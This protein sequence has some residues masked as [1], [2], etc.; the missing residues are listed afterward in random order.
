MTID[1]ELLLELVRPDA[2]GRVRK[3]ALIV[4]I[5]GTKEIQYKLEESTYY[6][7]SYGTGEDQKIEFVGITP[8]I[9][10]KIKPK[11]GVKEAFKKMVTEMVM[12]PEV[13]VALELENDIQWDFQDS[14]RQI[15][16]YKKK[17]EDTRIIIPE[18]YKRFAPLYKNE[19][20]RVYL[21]KAIRRWQC[22]RCGTVTGKEGP[23]QPKCKN[24]ECQN[25][26]RDEFRLIG[27]KDTE[28][29]EYKY[30][31]DMSEKPLF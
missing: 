16:K 11:R 30:S 22:L 19:G 20:F 18:E 10:V 29:E 27:L 6:T 5:I 7:E 21:W 23:I 28:I 12:G 4:S 24:K 26:S 17:F 1:D 13:G 3:E 8:D 14:L 9:T 15:K 25:K 31:L 2:R